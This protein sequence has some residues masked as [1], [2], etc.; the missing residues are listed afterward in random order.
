M[1][2]R[3]GQSVTRFDLFRI[4]PDAVLTHDASKKRYFASSKYTLLEV[5]IQ[6]VLTHQYK[7]L[8]DVESVD[9]YI[10]LSI[11]SP[12]MNEH[13]IEIARCEFPHISQQIRNA[14]I[15]RSRALLNPCGITSHSQ[16]LPLGVLT[17]VYG[18][19][20]FTH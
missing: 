13:V 7:N 8:S 2:A 5:G 4:E 12:S 20:T 1:S 6:L 11:R 14:S 17:A 3:T 9:F 10:R 15:E 19:V 18:D 16:R